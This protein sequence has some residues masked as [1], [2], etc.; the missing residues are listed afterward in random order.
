MVPW[1]GLQCVI[2]VFPDH[3]YL[4]FSCSVHLHNPG[5]CYT[6]GSS[7]YLILKM[8][9]DTA[10]NIPNAAKHDIA[11]YNVCGISTSTVVTTVES[12]GGTPSIDKTK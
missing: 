5:P 8:K 4:L 12:R 9:N 1:V 3:T 10:N 7:L 11:I 2:V 6:Y